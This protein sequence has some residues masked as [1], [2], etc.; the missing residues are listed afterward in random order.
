MQIRIIN[1]AKDGKV[2]PG[3]T[4]VTNKAEL[5]IGTLIGDKRRE[6]GEKFVKDL[7]ARIVYLKERD[8]L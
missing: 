1:P 4:P 6:L 2:V 3:L 5:A 7:R 8:L